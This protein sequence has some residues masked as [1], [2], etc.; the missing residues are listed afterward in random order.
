L[1]F[2]VLIPKISKTLLKNPPPERG[3]KKGHAHSWSQTLIS[4]RK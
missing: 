2:E 4:K 3:E 1:V